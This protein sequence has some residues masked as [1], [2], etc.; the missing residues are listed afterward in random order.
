[1]GA[2]ENIITDNLP[3]WSSAIQSKS[4]AGRGTSSK[5]NLYGVKK[6][7]EL[8]L[9]L[10][11]RGLLVP[12]DPS[13]EPASVLLEKVAA[14][15][16][17]LV[18][19]GK[20]KKQ[21]PLPNIEKIEENLPTNWKATRFGNVINILNGRAYKKNEMLSQGTPLLRVGNLFTSND[22]YY[23]DLE[24]EPN[25]YIDDGDLIYA[26]SASF[27]PFI[28]K[29]GKV[30]YHYH[31]WKLDF[32]DG[33]HLSKDYTYLYLANKTAAIKA[34]G[35]GI[36]ML[37]M[38]KERMEKLVF[39][40]P[41]LAEQHRIVAKVDELMALCD[42]LEKQQEDSIQ[43]HE[44]LVEVL[45]EALS[46]AVDADAFQTAWGRISEHFDVL[47]TTEHSINKL[48]E[49]IL[50][51]AVMGKL[52]PQDPSEVEITTQI[53]K[54]IRCKAKFAELNKTLRDKEKYVSRP[55]FTE[56]AN[57]GW[58]CLGEFMHVLGGKRVPAGYKLLN[59]KTD[60]VYL[61][62]TDMKNHSINQDDIKYIDPEI[63]DL[64]KKYIINSDDLYLT[65]AG[66]I[67]NVGSIPENLD[68]AN[69]TENAAKLVFGEMNKK[70]LIYALSSN[71]VQQQFENAVNQMAQPKLS[72]V[73]IK[74]TSIALPPKEE[75]HRIVAKVD[76]LMALCEQL[77]NSL[78][79]AQGTQIQL[80][81]AVVENA[82]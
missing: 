62:V 32:Y 5:R 20:I 74:F 77:K 54:A 43:A 10:A 26:W 58:Y 79:Q 4:S 80:T 40:I 82:L 17:S 42:T 19:G 21:K 51:L 27:G 41:P 29:G 1:M 13:D 55:Q 12:Q 8:I 68:G 76:E 22:W 16:G 34:A 52:V 53:E 28:W 48:K 60:Y 73:S 50:Q 49:T 36:A 72:L 38:T 69:L 64:I 57:W 15:K 9:D 61:R 7:R 66:T 70:F 39:P 30:I 35:N 71:Y 23:S 46:N 14:E 44:T 3:I 2:V 18:K 63:Y 45:L 59:D 47:F 65:I 81:D 56:P 25:K 75:Q 6:L 11:V 78:Q 31:I 33:S 24:L 37:H 67:G